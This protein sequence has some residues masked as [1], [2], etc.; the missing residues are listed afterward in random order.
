MAGIEWFEELGF[1]TN[2]FQEETRMIGNESLLEEIEY[3]IQ[4]GNIVLI[5]G[6]EGSG[7]TRILNELNNKFANAIMLNCSSLNFDIE[8]SLIKTTGFFARLFKKSIKNKIVLLDNVEKLSKQ[9]FELLKY[10]YETNKI[11]SIVFSSTSMPTAMPDNVKHT[12]IKTIQIEPISDYNAV[13]LFRDKIGYDFLEDATIREIW[14][15]S[16]RN[17]KKF[18]EN[19][20]RISKLKRKDIK[21]AE[22]A[23][24]LKEDDM[25]QRTRIL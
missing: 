9:D 7:K 2:P 23:K 10:M 15:C 21:P 12:I 6:T 25:V 1:E 24:L 5:K 11:R 18:I 20:E 8:S 19:S 4:A 13:Q 17:L 22:V 14:K 16:N 3:H